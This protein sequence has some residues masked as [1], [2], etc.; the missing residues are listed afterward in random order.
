MSI[1]LAIQ[2]NTK[3][4]YA[5]IAVMTGSMTAAQTIADELKADTP[6]DQP[7][8]AQAAV[9]DNTASN[10]SETASQAEVAVHETDAD[11]APTSSASE[12][13]KPATYEDTAA[14]VTQL[15]RT[16]GREI[17][18]AVLAKFGAGK[19]PDAKPEDYSAIIA[20]CEAA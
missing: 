11:D 4:I 20:A 15:A 10:T 5:M 1:E 7:S 16:K 6:V 12:D 19:L 2:E 8:Q 9:A 3:A 14:A 13:V 18:V 17:A